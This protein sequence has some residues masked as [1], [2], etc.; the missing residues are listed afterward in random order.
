MKKFI[1][2][3]L[4]C[5]LVSEVKPQ[6]CKQWDGKHQH[7]KLVLIRD[8]I[9]AQCG[10]CGEIIPILNDFG[11]VNNG[12]TTRAKLY[13]EVDGFI[14][15]DKNGLHKDQYLDENKKVLKKENIFGVKYGN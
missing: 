3:L 1:M 14:V 5:F 4:L 12:D 15:N 11:N 6:K 2:I 8:K 7:F 10:S 13:V 9:F